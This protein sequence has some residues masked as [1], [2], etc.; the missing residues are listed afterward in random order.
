MSR[1]EHIQVVKRTRDDGPGPKGNVKSKDD[2]W[3]AVVAGEGEPGCG[4]CG[5]S[6]SLSPPLT[7]TFSRHEGSGRCWLCGRPSPR[8]GRSSSPRVSQVSSSQ[9]LLLDDIYPVK[10]IEVSMEQRWNE[11]AGETGDPREN[12]PTR[13]VVRHDSSMRK[14]GSGPVGDLYILAYVLKDLTNEIKQRQFS[15]FARSLQSSSCVPHDALPAVIAGNFTSW[16]CGGVAVRLLAS[17]EGE[18]GSIPGRVTPGFPQV[19]ILPDDAVGWWVFSGISRFP[20]PCILA[21]LHFHLISRSSA[22]KTSMLRSAQTFQL[23]SSL[24]HT[25]KPTERM[26]MQE[27]WGSMAGGPIKLPTRP[28][29]VRSTSAH[30]VSHWFRQR[31]GWPCGDVVAGAK[32]ACNTRNC[33]LGTSAKKF[34][35]SIEDFVG[36]TAEEVDGTVPSVDDRAALVAVDAGSDVVDAASDVGVTAEEVDGTVP[37]VEDRSA[38]VAVDSGSD[39]GVTAEE[40]LQ[41]HENVWMCHCAESLVKLSLRA[42]FPASGRVTMDE[43]KLAL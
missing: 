23:C 29:L 4:T 31:L 27:V 9:R 16:G 22:L 43:R 42:V 32:E 15:D 34:D 10:V 25:T 13:G 12:P 1:T 20:H 11:R 2:P 18:P 8:R 28:A 5:L 19:G 17:H 37:S 30:L 33:V 39:V 3:R 40:C 35:D 41:G 7:H 26:Y 38:L 21:L 6:L 36:V 24:C 14:S